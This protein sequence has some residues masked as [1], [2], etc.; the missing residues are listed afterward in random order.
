MTT[1][2]S[3]FNNQLF[4]FLDDLITVFP[5]DN[6]FKTA[7]TSLELLKKTNPRKILELFRSYVVP[8]NDLIMN[9]N[10]DFFINED[11]DHLGGGEKGW[12]IVSKLKNYWK[13][14]S[15]SNK[16]TIW[17][18]FEILLLLNNKYN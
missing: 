10:E 8:Y 15:E 4:L 12:V 7:K 9:K 5:E 14:I 1:V 11:F 3:A 18:Y 16:Q 17:K 6:D 2:L 13:E